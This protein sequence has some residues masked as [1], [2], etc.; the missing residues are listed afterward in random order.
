MNPLFDLLEIERTN[1]QSVPYLGFVELKISFSKE[2]LGVCDGGIERTVD[3]V[4]SRFYW[5]KMAK[6][7]EEKI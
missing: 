5:P 1:G 2:F 7:V 6:D 4:R 3:L